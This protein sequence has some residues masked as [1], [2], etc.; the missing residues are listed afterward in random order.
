MPDM[1]SPPR[2]YS[3]E[4]PCGLPSPF[5]RDDTTHPPSG[6]LD[7][8]GEEPNTLISSMSHLSVSSLAHPDSPDQG[9]GRNLKHQH[10]QRFPDLPPPRLSSPLTSRV[11]Q[12]RIYLGPKL[13]D[14][15]TGGPDAGPLIERFSCLF[16]DRESLTCFPYHKRS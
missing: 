2:H 14:R 10:S 11:E 16:K 4:P 1:S 15:A 5:P 9:R 8:D 7:S 3:L 12:R 6:D 13:S